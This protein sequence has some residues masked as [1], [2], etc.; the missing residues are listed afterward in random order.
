MKHYFDQSAS[1]KLTHVFRVAGW[2]VIVEYD[3]QQKIIWEENRAMVQLFKNKNK[4]QN[5]NLYNYSQHLFIISD[6]YMMG[7]GGILLCAF[8]V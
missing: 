1:I 7:G 8:A 6:S 2:G 3:E 4:V 5:K